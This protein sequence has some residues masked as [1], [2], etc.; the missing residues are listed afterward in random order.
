M[1]TFIDRINQLPNLKI[2]IDIPSGLPSDSAPDKDASV[3]QA[4]HTLSFQFYK[5]SFM[6]PE[7]GIFAGSVH[8]LDIGLD[9]TF[10]N[11]TNSIYQTLDS[12]AVK[13]IYRPRNP[14]SHKGTYGHALIVAGS[15]GK[16]GAAT[17]TTKAA[18]RA[19]AGLVTA[20]IPGAGYHALQTAVPEA[21]CRIDSD[22][23]IE[24]IDCWQDMDAIG[25]GPG[26]GTAISTAT[27][28]ANFI[29]EYNKPLVAD[30]D[31]L[32]IIAK[33]PDLLSKLPKNTIITP[34]PK[35]FARLFGDT[36]NSM[37][38]VDHARIQAMRYNINI[39]LKN[40]HT[41]II[42][43]EG[44]CWYNTTGNAGMA[45]GGA[46]DVLTG[47]ITGLLAQGYQ[48]H[49][50]A[51]LGVYLH[52]MAGDIAAGEIS[53]EALVAGDIITY[54]SKAFLAPFRICQ[55]LIWPWNPGLYK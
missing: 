7:S 47:I 13:A 38:Q 49:E 19:G 36:T 33:Q 28:L 55:S 20:L 1:A 39:V 6:H 46:G 9:N 51:L 15:V 37:T 41:A 54:M 34:H 43:S 53:Q 25:I 30:A 42:T 40:H 23:H 4:Q 18:L 8:I 12:D 22:Q 50:A 32:N 21:M 35:E 44:E 2:A 29:E 31:A 11:A 26:L 16:I 27:A 45:T 14:F 48:P 10:I 5:R 52:G 17:L 3:I 24:N